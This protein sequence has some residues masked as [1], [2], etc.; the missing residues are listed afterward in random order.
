LSGRF[1]LLLFALGPGCYDLS[2]FD[3]CTDNANAAG[4]AAPA[5][6]CPGNLVTDPQFEGSGQGWSGHN[7]LLTLVANA[8][9]S[10]GAAHVCREGGPAYGI[11]QQTIPAPPMGASYHGSFWVRLDSPSPQD[12]QLVFYILGPY[13]NG[14]SSIVTIDPGPTWRE[15]EADF[16]IGQSGVPEVEL[17]IYSQMSV[18]TDACF[19]VDDVCVVRTR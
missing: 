10:G 7:G 16:P 17:D 4:C 5:S 19:Y 12:L 15:I 2:E 1:A 6:F 9:R 13:N 18:E 8:G 3:R 14:G 11:D